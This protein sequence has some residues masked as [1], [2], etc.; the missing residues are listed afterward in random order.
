MVKPRMFYET[1]NE[2]TGKR[3]VKTNLSMTNEKKTP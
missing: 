1:P 3:S 2:M